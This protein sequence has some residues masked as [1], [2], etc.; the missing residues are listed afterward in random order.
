MRNNI[1]N[2]DDFYF[3]NYL[4]SFRLKNKLQSHKKVCENKDSCYVEMPKSKQL[5]NTKI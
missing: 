4:H 5:N 1:K 3:L 2:N